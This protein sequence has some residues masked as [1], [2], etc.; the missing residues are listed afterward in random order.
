MKF[1]NPILNYSVYG[2]Y[3]T[4]AILGSIFFY[5]EEECI[6]EARGSKQ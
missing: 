1:F 5:A 6:I 3:C 2:F 4:P